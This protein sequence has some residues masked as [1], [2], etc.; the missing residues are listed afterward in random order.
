MVPLKL[1]RTDMVTIG[2]RTYI[3]R[4]ESNGFGG[5]IPMSV[6]CNG[7]TYERTTPGNVKYTHNGESRSMTARHF[8]DRDPDGFGLLYPRTA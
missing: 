7:D 6:T 1:A 5:S 2:G 8:E 4:R 3:V